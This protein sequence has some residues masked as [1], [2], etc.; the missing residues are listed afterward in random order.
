MKEVYLMHLTER[1]QQNIGVCVVF[2]A[3][4]VILLIQHAYV[5]LYL[6]DYG[7]ASLSFL[8]TIPNVDGTNFNLSQFFEYYKLHYMTISGRVLF[9]GFETLLLKG[10]LW[11]MRIAQSAVIT[12][13][14]FSIYRIIIS[15][16]KTQ[17]ITAALAV[18]SM[19][20]L[21]E[22]FLL[23]KSIYWFTG[24]VMYLWPMLP[25]FVG[26]WLFYRYSYME[27]RPFG[28]LKKA[29]MVVCILLAAMGQ[30]QVAAAEI[31][32]VLLIF[33]AKKR[34][35]IKFT[36]MD[37]AV[38]LA[39]VAGLI[40]IYLAPGA[41]AR[42]ELLHHEVGYAEFYT[43]PLAEKISTA[44][45]NIERHIFSENMFLF[46]MAV[47]L[48]S[49][50]SA[51]RLIQKKKGIR[52]V[53]Y[54]LVIVDIICIVALL[55][56]QGGIFWALDRRGLS[57]L[58]YIGV[59]IA[60]VFLIYGFT[61]YYRFNRRKFVLFSFYA[62]LVSVFCLVVVLPPQSGRFY[63]PFAFLTLVLIGDI[64]CDLISTANRKWATWTVIGV[65]LATACF[66]MTAQTLKYYYRS[67]M[68]EENQQ[69]LTETA[70]KIH[71]GEDIKEVTLHFFPNIE[72]NA[73][74]PP[75][76]ILTMYQEG[77]L[78]DIREYYGLPPDLIIRWI[79]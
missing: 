25:L 21:L 47:F 69:V 16:F 77:T 76:G 15:Q 79:Y 40:F 7:Y 59:T 19:Y 52:A 73:V 50:F 51:V 2:L 37:T 32:I 5:Y 38:I 72:S 17:R 27:E 45:L 53:N 43:L 75:K 24:S 18:V 10:G 55:F 39:A 44:F 70:Q 56:K 30:E 1:K 54:L 6:D 60:L 58:Y 35:R 68:Q 42:V 46:M 64:V 12:L 3:F 62:G 22:I 48:T 28:A 13:I 41:K 23:D 63:I 71:A 49:I 61:A 4:F 78:K 8:N 34:G 65:L 29:G 11:M 9:L 66:N 57:E 14:M 20:G 67:P 74:I 31:V 36:K 26:S 33:L